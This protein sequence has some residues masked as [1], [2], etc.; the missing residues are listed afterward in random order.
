MHPQHFPQEISKTRRRAYTSDRTCRAVKARINNVLQKCF[1][2]EAGTSRDPCSQIYDGRTPFSEPETRA[3]ADFIG[4]RN[5][6][7]KA[8]V[9]LHSYGQLWMAP[10]GYTTS[11]P[12][13]FADMVSRRS[14][15]SL[16][17][18]S[19]V[20]FSLFNIT[21]GLFYKVRVSD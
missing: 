17:I 11:K 18:Y 21:F 20:I 4:A 10:Y 6:T 8:F 2:P 19:D 7:W 15:T 13:N 16:P 5:G 14:M 12:D 1:D 3:V 9:T